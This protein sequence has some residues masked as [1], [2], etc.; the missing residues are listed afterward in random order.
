MKSLFERH[1]IGAGR[2]LLAAEGAEPTGRDTHIGRVDMAVDVEVGAVA[3]HP[4]GTELASQPT[5][6]MSPVR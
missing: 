1:G 3:V 6:R 2:I 4:F 5:A